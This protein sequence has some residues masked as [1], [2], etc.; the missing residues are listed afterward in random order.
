MSLFSVELPDNTAI[1]PQ[2]GVK[3]DI[4]GFHSCGG[5][6]DEAVKEAIAIRDKW[7]I[8]HMQMLGFIPI[9]HTILHQYHDNHIHAPDCAL[10]RWEYFK[11][12]LEEKDGCN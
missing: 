1:C 12:S 6:I 10:C 7:W 4:Y 8:E 2:C 9:Q 5:S 11:Q 3:Y